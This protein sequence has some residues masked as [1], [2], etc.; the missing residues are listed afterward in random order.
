MATT[1]IEYQR[2]ERGILHFFSSQADFEAGAAGAE[3]MRR[4]GVDRRVLGP[5]E[6]LKV[7]PALAAF[8]PNIHGGT[9]TAQRRIG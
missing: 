8:G 9:F 6:V 1:G 3:L 5:D 2:L 7:E 4:C